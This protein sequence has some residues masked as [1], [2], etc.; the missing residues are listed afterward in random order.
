MTDSKVVY[1]LGVNHGGLIPM[2]LK[3]ESHDEIE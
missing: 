2:C 3:R 1:V